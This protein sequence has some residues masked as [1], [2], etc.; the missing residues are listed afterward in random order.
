MIGRRRRAVAAEEPIDLEV[1]GRHV[2]ITHPGRVIWPATGTTKRELVDYLLAVAPV[3]LPHLRRRATMLWRFPEGVDGPG[4]FQ[5]QCRGRPPW[6]DTFDVTARTG[7]TLRYCVIEEPATLA[8]LANLGTIEFH[9]HAWH[10]DR[11]MVPTHIVF[12]L[13]PGPP[14]GLREAADAALL[15]AHRLR[16]AGLTPI[17]KTSGSLGLHVAALLDQ[18]E[19]FS[20]AKAFAR[21]LAEE[22]ATS[23]AG[24]VIARSQR[25]ARAGRVYLDWIQ[26]DRNR[27]LV[28]P[29]SPRATGVPRVSTP[30]TWAEVEGAARGEVGGL[31]P[32]FGEV[33]ARIESLGDVW[34]AAEPGS[35]RLSSPAIDR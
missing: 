14:A 23:S 1:G 9:P 13:D 3:L 32:T 20:R 22:L 35:G 30:L 29:Y 7:E 16:T 27:Q 6:V 5:A 24:L 12:D 15:V 34:T 21:Q 18:R 25:T 11:P 31:R 26:N 19:T 10:I 2:R 33:L 17:V 4:W 28:A 8:W